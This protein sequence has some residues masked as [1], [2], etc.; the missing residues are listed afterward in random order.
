MDLTVRQVAAIFD[1]PEGRIYRWIHDDGLPSR[2]VNGN[3]Y[4]NR[5]E[6][7]EWATVR[8]VKFDPDLFRDP[9]AGPTSRRAAGGRAFDR[10]NHHRA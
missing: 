5:T 6:L 7:L 2:Q 3:Q 9:E 1:V 4:F 8:R 10:G